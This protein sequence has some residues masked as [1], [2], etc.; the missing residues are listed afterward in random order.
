MPS[1]VFYPPLD[2]DGWRCWEEK[3]RLIC[4]HDRELFRPVKEESVQEQHTNKKHKSNTNKTQKVHK[5]KLKSHSK[6]SRKCEELQ[7]YSL[8]NKNGTNDVELVGECGGIFFFNFQNSVC[9][10]LFLLMFGFGKAIPKRGRKVA[11]CI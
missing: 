6:G 2:Q 4:R 8:A 5:K 3:V 9:F 1:L 11:R 7:C 10:Y